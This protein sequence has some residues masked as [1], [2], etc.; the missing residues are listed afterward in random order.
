M[1]SGDTPD[2]NQ[3]LEQAQQMQQQLMQAQQQLAEQR[4]RGN[5]EDLA[6]RGTGM[7]DEG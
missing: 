5:A 6:H 4:L 7:R 3:L 1:F 2:M